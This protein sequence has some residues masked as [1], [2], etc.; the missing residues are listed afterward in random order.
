MISIRVDTKGIEKRIERLGLDVGKVLAKSINLTAEQAQRDMLDAGRQRFQI[1]KESYYRR[2]VRIKPFA[3]ATSL[4]AT[5][6]VPAESVL[7]KFERGGTKTAKGRSVAIPRS[8]RASKAS[9][10]PKSKY[11]KNLKNKFE[12]NDGGKRFLMYR[13]GR[14]KNAKIFVAYRLVRSVR[15]KPTLRFVETVKHSVNQHY[16]RNVDAAIAR[17]VAKANAG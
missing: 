10:I 7:N 9:V 5:I 15:I 8:V 16:T 3:K 6:E 4:S 1:R 12:I 17:E 13:R 2:Q 11:P 14:G